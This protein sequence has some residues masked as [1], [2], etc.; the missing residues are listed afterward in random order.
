MAVGLPF[1]AVE[2]GVEVLQCLVVEVAAVEAEGRPPWEVPMLVALGHHSRSNPRPYPTSSSWPP[3]WLQD[4]L[5]GAH[6]NLN[7]IRCRRCWLPFAR[8]LWRPYCL[9]GRPDLHPL[10]WV[11]VAVAVAAGYHLH[12]EAEVEVVDLQWNDLKS[13]L[14]ARRRFERDLN[15]V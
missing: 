8:L 6:P 11:V 4:F 10:A 1:L 13:R 5:R 3:A 2:A 14:R 12:R 9:A 15:G 7:R